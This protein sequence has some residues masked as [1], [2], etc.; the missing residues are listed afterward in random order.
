MDIYIYNGVFIGQ[1]INKQ[2]ASSIQEKQFKKK[3][4]DYRGFSGPIVK[5]HNSQLKK[6][7]DLLWHF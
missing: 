4:I 6:Q 5:F 2:V 7:I 1:V 3:K